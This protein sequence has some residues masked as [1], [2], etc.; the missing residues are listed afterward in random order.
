MIHNLEI[1]EADM[2]GMEEALLNRM[3]NKNLTKKKTFE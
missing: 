1:N 3:R 2:P